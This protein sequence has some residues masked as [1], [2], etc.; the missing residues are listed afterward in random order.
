MTKQDKSES[1]KTLDFRQKEEL[2]SLMVSLSANVDKDYRVKQLLLK[3]EAAT[4]FVDEALEFQKTHKLSVEE[5]LF[6]IGINAIDKK[7]FEYYYAKR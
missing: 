5:L 2:A 1:E 6:V 7:P 3:H 4:K